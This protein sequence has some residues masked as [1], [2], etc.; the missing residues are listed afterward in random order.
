MGLVG[1]NLLQLEQRKEP[2]DRIEVVARWAN[3]DAPDP[4]PAAATAAGAGIA[5]ARIE[6]SGYCKGQRHLPD[7]KII[8]AYQFATAAEL[9]RCQTADTPVLRATGLARNRIHLP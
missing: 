1:A 3:L 7:S 5:D 2:T 4:E 8:T 9:S 6:H